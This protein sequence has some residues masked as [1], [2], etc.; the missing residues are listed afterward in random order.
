MKSRFY[1][2]TKE[3]IYDAIISSSTQKEC[4]NKLG[5]KHERNIDTFKKVVL[6]YGFQT[7][8]EELKQRS[9][10]FN[11]THLKKI[12]TNNCLNKDL[13]PKIFKENSNFDRGSIKRYITRNNLIDYVCAK[14]GNKGEWQG[15]KL[16]LQLHHIN[17]INN[18]NRLENLTFLCPNC[19]S[20]TDTFGT[21]DPNKEKLKKLEQ[22]TKRAKRELVKQEEINNRKKY[23]DSIDTSKYGWISKAEKDLG[24]SHTQI[25]RWINKYYP[26]LQV[27]SRKPG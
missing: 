17:G 15:E 10:E 9:K 24:I 26:E 19:H 13:E 11:K 14:C 3:E 21:K 1:N 8:F 4:L 12:T 20:Q 25:R 23:F 7:E 18:D 22:E 27:F 2:F 6:E 5:F 16:N